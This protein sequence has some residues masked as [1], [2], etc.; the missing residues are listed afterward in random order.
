MEREGK[1]FLE[2]WEEFQSKSQE[3][4]IELIYIKPHAASSKRVLK[5]WSKDI[6]KRRLVLVL[7]I[8]ICFIDIVNIV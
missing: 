4:G 1:Y 6:R 5:E 2:G 7:E 3:K 8:W